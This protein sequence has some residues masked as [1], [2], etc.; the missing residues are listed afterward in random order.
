M[1]GSKTQELRKKVEYR[2]EEINSEFEQNRLFLQNKQEA[3]LKEMQDEEMDILTKL[4]ENV[5]TLS[6]HASTLK[7]L[8]KEVKDKCA[9]SDLT[10]L[11]R[12]KSICNR[13]RSLKCPELFSFSLKKYSFSLPPQYSGLDRIIKQFPVE[14]TFDLDTAH[15]H[16]TVSADRKVVHYR[17]T[18]QNVY[19]SPRRFYL[20]PAV[21]GLKAFNSGRHYWEVAVGNKPKWTLGVCQNHLPRNWRNQPAVLGDFWAIGRYI[22]SGYIAFGPRRTRLL[23]EVRPSKVGIFLDYEMGEVSFYNVND[24]SLLYTFNDAFTKTIWPYFYTGIDPEPLKI[25]SVPDYGK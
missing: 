9:R 25:L 19:Y 24:R 23:P 16:L 11:T 22:E 8:L 17:R 7:G 3:I 6:D 12:V 4:N 14:M 13:Y 1:Q 2:K 10:L 18:R 20:C 21:L 5:A 15:P